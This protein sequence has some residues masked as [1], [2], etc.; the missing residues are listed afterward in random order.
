MLKITEEGVIYARVSSSRQIRE[1]RGLQSQV[2]A[3]KRYAIENDIKILAVFEDPAQS[4]KD[5]NRP[6]IISLLSFLSK[7]KD[8]TYVIVED[9]SRLSRNIREY[10]ALKD[11]IQGKKG[12][13][14]DLKNQIQSDQQEILLKHVIEPLFYIKLQNYSTLIA[15][16]DYLKI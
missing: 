12:L 11:L 1:G 7:R 10:Y 9:I 13:L 6:G 16:L 15:Y 8:F 14:K 2:S 4:G 5:L 3:C